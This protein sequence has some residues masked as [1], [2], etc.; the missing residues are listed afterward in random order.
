MLAKGPRHQPAFPKPDQSSARPLAGHF[1][2]GRRTL[3]LA[4]RPA[5]HPRPVHSLFRRAPRRQRRF[6]ELL[7][8]SAPPAPLPTTS[9]IASLTSL[10]HP[11]PRRAHNN[12]AAASVI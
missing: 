4:A 5:P 12:S 8:F 2:L 7:T 1:A 6:S 11:E 9:A 10:V 3:P